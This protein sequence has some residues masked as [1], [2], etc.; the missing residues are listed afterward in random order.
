MVPTTTSPFRFRFVFAV[1][2][3]VIVVPLILDATGPH[4]FLSQ[5]SVLG[6]VDIAGGSEADDLFGTA[7]AVGDFNGDGIGDVAVGSPG[8]TVTVSEQGA[9]NVVYGSGGGLTGAG[10]QFWDLTNAALSG[11]PQSDDHFGA[12]LA[13]GNFDGDGY[14]DL[15]IGV[16]GRNSDAGAVA[17][18]YG[19][20]N[21]LRTAGFQLWSQNSSLAGVAIQGTSR[22]GDMFG[23]AVAAGDINGDGVDD[24]VVGVPFEDEAL[25]S[26]T[27]TNGAVNF[28]YGLAGVGLTARDNILVVPDRFVDG[29]GSFD[30][31]EFG[32]AL[33]IGDFRGWGRPQVA[34]GA[35]GWNECGV[36]SLYACDDMGAVYLVDA[37]QKS[38]GEDAGVFIRQGHGGVP[39]G[40]QGG[41]RFGAALAAG[42]FDGDGLAEL[43]IG[44][45]GEDLGDII[46]AGMVGVVKGSPSGLTSAGYQTW[47]QDITGV[48]GGAHD[49]E[50]FGSA[51]AVGHFDEDA[52]LDLAIGTPGDLINNVA[53]GSVTILFGRGAGLTSADQLWTQDGIGVAGDANDIFG[54]PQADDRFGGALAA[55]DFFGRGFDGLVV[56]VPGENDDA[57]SVNTLYGVGDEPRAVGADVSTNEDVS[58]TFNI[59]GRDPQGNPLTFAVQTP[60]TG[61][62]F[63]G[64][65][66]HGFLSTP[67]AINATSAQVRY[68]PIDNWYG[69]ETFTFTVS[70]GTYTS[71]PATVSIRVNAVNDP[72]YAYPSSGTAPEDGVGYLRI[73]GADVETQSAEL[74]YHLSVWPT[75][76]TVNTDPAG[77]LLRYTCP[78]QP[79]SLCA[80][81]T[82]SANFHGADSFSFT[83]G[84]GQV[85]S[86]P[87]TV[88][89]IV[90]PVNDPPVTSSQAVFAKEN[91]PKIFRLVATDIDNDPLTFSLASPP[92]FGTVSFDPADSALVTYNSGSGRWGSTQLWFTVSDGATTSLGVV[93]MFVQHVLSCQAGSY[94]AAPTDPSCTPAPPG[95]FVPSPGATSPTACQP[96]TYSD[97]PGAVACTP[98]PAGSH[99]ALPGASSA[100]LCAAGTFSAMPGA[101]VCT[102]APAGSYATGP[103][104]ITSAACTVGTFSDAPGAAMC[105]SAP[106]GGYVDTPGATGPAWCGPGSYSASEGATA[107]TPAQPGTF[108]AQARQTIA[109]RCVPGTYSPAEGAT[110]CLLAPLGMFVSDTGAATALRCEPGTYSA[111]E[112]AAACTPA[113]PGTYVSESG[114]ANALVC[115]VGRYQPNEGQ[116]SCLDGTICPAGFATVSPAGG[117]SDTVC[118]PDTDND[119]ILNTVDNCPVVANADQRNTDL[120]DAGDACD[121]DDDNDGVTDAAEDELGTDPLVADTD[122][123]TWSDSKELSCRSDPR[124]AT[125]VPGDNDLDGT[126]NCDDT[127]DDNDGVLDVNDPDIDGDGIANEIDAG[128]DSRLNTHFIGGHGTATVCTAWNTISYFSTETGQM[129]SKQACSAWGIGNVSLNGEVTS[130][131]GTKLLRMFNSGGYDGIPS[132]TEVIINPDSTDRLTVVACGGYVI[133]SDTGNYSFFCGSLHLTATQGSVRARLDGTGEAYVTVTNG[134]SVVIDAL[135][136]ANGLTTYRVSDEG[137]QGAVTVTTSQGT[138]QLASGT[139]VDV[140]VAAPAD[141]DGDGVIDTA[142]NCP[143]ITNADQAD[144]DHDGIG[145]QCDGDRSIAA[146]AAAPPA[147]CAVDPLTG[148]ARDTDLDGVP[149]CLDPDADNDGLSNLDE[150]A[151]G[152]DPLDPD[153]DGDGAPDGADRWP[154]DATK[155]ADILGPVIS[156]PATITLPA[157]SPAGAVATWAVPTA[158]DTVDGPVG[159]ACAP[160]SGAL[161]PIGVTTVTCTSADT[162]GNRSTSTFTVTVTDVTTPGEMRGNGHLRSGDAKVQFSFDVREGASGERGNLSVQ[163]EDH[164]SRG[165]SD[166]SGKSLRK[167]DRFRATAVTFVAFS[168]D[169]TTRPGR[170]HKVQIDTVRFMGTGEWN[171][172]SGYTFDV[173]AVDQGEPGRHRETITIVIRDSA[174]QIVAE[175]AGELVD[176]N[177]QSARIPHG[178]DVRGKKD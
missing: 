64:Q 99:V 150:A 7:T 126:I 71:T 79:G 129:V 85:V 50:W 156:A 110:A 131:A 120:D 159:V 166:K 4:R 173:L 28:L 134:A 133:D 94:A 21:G 59:E 38:V 63:P 89:V 33:A 153:A 2:A 3:V 69:V 125:S 87:A 66:A 123:D 43:A 135:S 130:G 12:A 47:H 73:Q 15:A 132:R 65:L 93:N 161:F 114:A 16:P 157:E 168:D 17:I 98:A 56:G 122:G 158:I 102:P 175:A 152:L 40:Q 13:V 106:A 96:G 144:G 124:V 19:S 55:G 139:S 31:A 145:D 62:C 92:E 42:D 41:D 61:V 97:A 138:Q 57:G 105:T 52:G 101:V 10:N 27:Q 103:G 25:Y 70:D 11:S 83:V 100:T 112:G 54:A 76:G 146:E 109:L 163:V 86:A 155:S 20:Q 49:D 149:D 113:S 9:V 141:Q 46:D 154:A 84:D 91:E 176:G 53:A 45:P 74:E 30:D 60:C 6:G 127:D 34:V 137:T 104:A 32:A 1:L 37:R 140:T 171:G 136:T 8:E 77:R 121:S 164:D 22:G 177:V 95:S 119:G 174:G 143:V 75:N 29:E 165:K 48:Q 178:R 39:G 82:P 111:L 44:V 167:D 90:T 51:L 14:D 18:L 107:C 35:P 68:T 88:G 108:V 67:Q 160:L 78:S 116:V 58:L 80:R 147:D 170:D 162:T 151:A 117:V 26:N 23:A 118:A 128:P 115:P 142:D 169:P 24:L 172:R 36:I 148:A 5:N 81:Y 72:P